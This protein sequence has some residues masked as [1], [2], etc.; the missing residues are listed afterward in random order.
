MRPWRTAP[1]RGRTLAA[2]AV[3]ALPLGGLAA[4]PVAAA[5]GA[6]LP[7][8]QQAFD[9][10]GI[11]GS[12]SA[13]AGNYDG[14]GDSFSAASLAADALSPGR[15]L[16]HDGLTIRWPD[17]APGAPGQRRGRRAD[18]GGDGRRH[19]PRRRRR[20]RLRRTT[21]TFTV[22][23]ATGRRAASTVSLGDW[24]DTS[25]PAGTDTLATTGGWNSGGTIPVSLFY[26]AIPLTAGKQVASVTLPAVGA[27]VGGN[28]PSMHIFSLTIG[29]PGAEAAGAPGAASYYD[30]G[31]KDC[32]GTAA[33]RRL[34]G[35]VHG[36]GRHAVRCLRADDRQ[37]RRQEPRPDRH[38]A[39]LHRAAAPRHDL[40]GRGARR[41]R[42]GLRGHRARCRARLQR[43]HR[44]H[45]RPVGR[46]RGD[47]L[48]ARPAARRARRPAPVPATS[49]RC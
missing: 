11:T 23:Y 31:R 1:R 5:D 4:A 48:H 6:T 30:E 21:G 27:S 10:V 14:I 3:I 8:L 42:D 22:N 28:V 2:L 12:A 45:H 16:L 9:N 18:R 46:G 17:V 13:S 7:T 32:V 40:H 33:S 44:L 49:T 39:R 43:G 37:H 34:E 26:A 35:L 15:T 19:D 36:R 29:A 38:R 24:I 20:V 41:H 25:A 47:A